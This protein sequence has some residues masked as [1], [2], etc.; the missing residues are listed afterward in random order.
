VAEQPVVTLD[1]VSR[2]YR[3]VVALAAL[4][5]EV[6]S[7]SV[8]MLLG[9]NGAG[10]TTAIRVITGVVVPQHGRVRTF[11]VDPAG[12]EGP[13]VRARCGVVPARP[14]LYDRLDGRANP[15]YAAA[16]HGFERA[17]A[18]ERV[19]AAAR[20]FGIDHALAQ[21]VGGYSTGM[22]ARLALARATLHDPDL[23]LLDEPTAGLDPESAP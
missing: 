10:K 6:R 16:L 2:T 19:V 5:L 23:L 13:A 21:R 17:D 12:A 11:G 7:R 4:D 9:P 20:R 14:A 22:R 15:A 1:G 8:T 3:S 18:D